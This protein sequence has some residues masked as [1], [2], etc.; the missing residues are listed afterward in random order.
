M[1]FSRSSLLRVALALAFLTVGV[2]AAPPPPPSPI[3]PGDI[4]EW[5]G[6]I[7]SDE[8]EGRQVFTE[9]LGLA[10]A[11]IAD[12]LAAWN[13]KPGGEDGTYFQ[14]VKVL[15]VRTTS[16]ASVTVMVNGQTRVFKDG[17]GIFFPKKM[18]GR[19]SITGDRVQFVGYGLQVPAADEDDYA[20]VDPGGKHRHLPRPG[21][22]NA[23]SQFIPA[24]ECQVAQRDCQGGDRDDRTG[25]GRQRNARHPGLHARARRSGGAGARVA[26][27]Q[28]PRERRLHHGRTLR[29]AG[30]SGAHCN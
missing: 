20:G 2:G 30:G 5:L 9:G 14:T 22:E 28:W 11:Y 27:F 6:Y 7:A 16:K 24:P 8:L 18:G 29:F 13:V 15:G 23:A 17:E 21:R 26:P 4:R 10:A 3:Q 25:V 19:Q 1:R 12:H